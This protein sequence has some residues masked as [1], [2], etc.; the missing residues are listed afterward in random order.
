M[1]LL[2]KRPQNIKAKTINSKTTTKIKAMNLIIK[3]CYKKNLSD[4]FLKSKT[5]RNIEAMNL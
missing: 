4:T 2:N 5:A 1:D 3:D